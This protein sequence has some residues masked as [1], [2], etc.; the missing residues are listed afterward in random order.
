MNDDI[1]IVK[2]IKKRQIEEGGKYDNKKD[3]WYRC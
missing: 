3:K 2:Q 1:I